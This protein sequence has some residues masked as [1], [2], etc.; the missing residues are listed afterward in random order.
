LENSPRDLIQIRRGNT[1]NLPTLAQGEMAFTLDDERVYV[2]GANGNIGFAMLEEFEAF[3]NNAAALRNVKDYGVLGVSDG[4]MDSTAMLNALPGGFH[5]VFTD[6]Y[7]INGQGD[8]SGYG[9]FEPKE[10]TI[11]TFMKGSKLKIIPQVSDVYN[12]IWITDKKG[13][14]FNNLTIEGDR[15]GHLGVGGQFGYGIQIREDSD[16]ILNNAYI[17]DCWGDGIFISTIAPS[18]VILNNCV[19]DNNRRQGMSIIRCGVVKG[20]GNT[21]SNTNGTAPQS[22]IDV[23]PN[24]PGEVIG[25]I[26]LDNTILKGN[27]GAGFGIYGGAG[28]LSAYTITLNNPIIENNNVGFAC[29]SLDFSKFGSININNPKIVGGGNAF[30][31]NDSQANIRVTNPKLINNIY[32]FIFTA[33]AAGHSVKNFKAD[34]VEVFVDDA[35]LVNVLRLYGSYTFEN[36]EIDIIKNDFP[37]HNK[38][39]SSVVGTAGKFRYNTGH[40][41][42]PVADVFTNSIAFYRFST[43]SNRDRTAILTVQLDEANTT[44]NNNEITLLVERVEGIQIIAGTKTIYPIDLTSIKSTQIGAKIKLR[45]NGTAWIII[46]KV[47]DWIA[48]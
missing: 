3:K 37:A 29:Q 28:D 21:F 39:Y 47:G 1:A 18:V 31:I 32:P 40:T 13:I 7:M 22:G 23:E 25:V 24:F 33:N 26:E 16:V 36:I 38:I 10:N 44:L 5:Y 14:V 45:Y 46:E 20:W 2:G 11:Y 35:V 48:V 27:A 17:Y 9:G 6:T 34:N 8:Y 12:A 19:S 43:I 15:A 4:V 41:A 30:A 42:Y